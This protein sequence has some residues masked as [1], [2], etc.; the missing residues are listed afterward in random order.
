MKTGT[1][2]LIGVGAFILYDLSQLSTAVGTVQVLFSGI[3]INN[4]VNY[5]VTLT[6][7]NISNI[8]VAVNGM[9]GNVLLNGNE[10]ASISDFT[11]RQ[12]P[13]RGQVDIPVT[14]TPSLFDL[15]SN[16]ADLLQTSGQNLNFTVDGNVNVNG[17]VLPFTL[18]KAIT[19]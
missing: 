10:L 19:I 7:Q 6:V 11:V 12:V 17:L 3:K 16:I 13:A 4:V 9:T 14:V 2:A 8:A 18:D 5:T 1:I 15:P